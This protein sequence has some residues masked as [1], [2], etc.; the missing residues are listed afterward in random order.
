MYRSNRRELRWRFLLPTISFV[1]LLGIAF[2]GCGNNFGTSTGSTGSTPTPSP[3]AQASTSSCPNTTA[4][5]TA[6]P[7]ANVVLKNSDNNHSVTVKQGD[8]VEID[9]PMGNLW[10]QQSGASA[11]LLTA[12]TPSGY[13]NTTTQM[14]VW[15][16]VASTAGTANL[17]FVGRPICKKGSACPQY[18][19]ALS[20]VLDI[21]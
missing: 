5:T 14:C 16:F 6:P 13:A 19:V 17:N 2:A 1:A 3:T 18:V 9:L 4:V 10:T 15:R 8:T 20:F 7:S 12:Q 21:K 11:N